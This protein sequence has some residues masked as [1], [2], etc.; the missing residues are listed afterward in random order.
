MVALPRRTDWPAIGNCSV[1]FDQ[2]SNFFIQSRPCFQSLTLPGETFPLTRG[3]TGKLTEL[4]TQFAPLQNSPQLCR[5]R[6][7]SGRQLNPLFPMTA[8]PQNQPT[9]RSITPARCRPQPNPITTKKSQFPP[10]GSRLPHRLHHH[11]A[12]QLLLCP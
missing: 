3:L 6:F 9:A 7:P 2:L 8:L 12:L 4:K 5:L 10:L 1:T 11:P